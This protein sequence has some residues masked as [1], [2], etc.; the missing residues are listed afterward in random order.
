M[1]NGWVGFHR[2]DPDELEAFLAAVEDGSPAFDGGVA[3]I[4]GTMP[5]KGNRLEDRA[6][7]LA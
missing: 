5:G 6:A 2:V 7:R 4:C 1:P 3:A